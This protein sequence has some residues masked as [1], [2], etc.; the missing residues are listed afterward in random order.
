MEDSQVVAY[1]ARLLQRSG[2][3]AVLAQ[4]GQI[5]W[6]EGVAALNSS[7]YRGSVDGI[8]RFYQAEWLA[9]LPRA[10]QWEPYFQDG[11]T[12]VI[13][14]GYAAVSESKRFPLI[15]DQLSA[16]MRTWRTLMPETRAPG[17][18]PAHAIDE[19][20]LKTSYSNNGDSI[21]MREFTPKNTWL[22]V[23][24]ESRLNPSAWLAQ[25][26]FHP[27]QL[28]T[29]IGPVYPCVGVYTINGKTA[30]AYGR[31]AHKAWVDFT[32][33]DAAILVERGKHGF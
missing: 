11:V 18:V 7:V 25:K 32:A 20:V 30:G 4:P 5:I 3:E 17:D 1:L 2:R 15:W 8:V 28:R 6:N 12:P 16:P 19:W 23:A 27:A 29:P 26:R 22:R 24:L 10:V 9:A 31:L 13:N 14:P 21:F 33:V